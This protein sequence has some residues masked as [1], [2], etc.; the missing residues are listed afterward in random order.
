M[1][2][3]YRPSPSLA[4]ATAAREYVPPS[5]PATVPAPSPVL[6][7]P[8][9][10]E[11]GRAVFVLALAPVELSLSSSVSPPTAT[12][13]PLSTSLGIGVISVPNSLSIR[14]RL[15]RSS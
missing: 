1:F 3:S 14:S 6:G 7:V 11:A 4:V 15:N 2:I 5:V 9:V 12:Y 13:N 8:I 10:V